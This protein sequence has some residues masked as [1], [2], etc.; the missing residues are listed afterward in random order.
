MID[1]PNCGAENPAGFRFCGSCAAPLP[2]SPAPREQR[3]TVSVLFCD[4]TGSTALGESTDPETLRAQLARYFERMKAIVQA[5][6]GSVEKFIGD[7]VMAIFGVPHVHE[8]DALRAVRAA[9][10][11]RDAL[12]EL[13]LQARIGVNTGE[14]VT[15][16]DERLATGDAVNVAARLEQAATPGEILIGHATFELVRGSVEALPVDPLTVKGKSEPVT[17]HRLVAVLAGTASSPTRHLESPMVGRQTEVRRLADAYEQALRNRSCQMFTILG[18]AGVGKSRLAAEFQQGVDANVVPGRCL[19]YGEGITYWPVI[20]VIRQLPAVQP[21]AAV[22]ETLRSLVDGTATAA[23]ADEIAWAFRKLLEAAARERPLVVVFDDLQWGEETFLDLVEHVA[24]LS[25]DAPI[26][27]LCM[28]RPDLLDRRPTWA[29]GKLNATNVLLEPLSVTETQELIAQLTAPLPGDT[30]QRVVDAAEGNP[31]FVEE[32]VALARGSSA[33]QVFVPPT[34]QALLAARLDQ[35][36]DGERAVLER[37]SIEG[38][39]F[40][41]SALQALAPDQRDGPDQRDV[42]KR[43]TSLVRKELIRP[44]TSRVPGDDAFRFRHLLIRDAAYEALPKSTRA[45]LHERFSR[46]LE[47]HATSVTELDEIL[48]YHLEQACRYR[49]EL[50]QP[51]DEQVAAR[52]RDHLA[53]A[54]RR[55]YARADFGAA[56]A[57][58]ER[59]G[60]QLPAGVIDMALSVDLTNALRENGRSDD[61]LVY[62]TSLAERARSTGDRGAELCSLILAGILRTYREPEGAADYL[63]ELTKDAIPYFEDAHDDL[64]LY[65]AYHARGQ[66]AN[67]R[68]QAV[69][70]VEAYDR[71]AE[72]ARRLGLADQFLVWRSLFRV[73]GTTPASE[74]LAWLEA[75]TEGKP[76]ALANE[77]LRA[78]ALA[79][80]GRTDEAR[81]VIA[82]AVRELEDRG[83]QVTIGEALGFGA[84]VIELLA[85][86]A[87][88]AVAAGEEGC[89]LLEATGEVSFVSAV[90]G[91]L[92]RALV[93]AGRL[94]AADLW[95]R[96]ASELSTSDDLASEMIW[97][98]AQALVLAHRGE[99]TAA[100]KLAQEA[101]SIGAQTQHLNEQ[102]ETYWDLATVLV[103]GD[104]PAEAAEALREAL[105]R[106]E[107]KENLVMA[108]R[109]RRK[110]ESLA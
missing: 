96:R 15:G 20:E 72:Y 55:A 38:R 29:G 76:R 69:A 71:A 50:G 94:D 73:L 11:M 35:L 102:G 43:L 97:R 79:M 9:V 57:L 99:H 37:G 49:R 48:G 18:S 40:H 63:D 75:Q 31:L 67:V 44:D 53:S 105:D 4:V 41:L 74:F 13:G 21:E 1:C 68:A 88:A 58:F 62:T 30:F 66:A 3:K 82:N 107:R 90:A 108:E 106:Y 65:V 8:D 77:Q 32:M 36:D 2:D 22:S 83:A 86:D 12:P 46:W 109:A 28:A 100:K 61:A 24:D 84:L 60:G 45:D 81:S 92:A 70:G 98:Q 103:L 17:A 6:G 14:V 10:E 95:A 52:A 42:M 110:L 85:G 47:E 25:R 51:V 101:V 33:G 16:T 89:R 78:T 64:G 56:V 104:Q 23:S 59:A 26:L 34:I 87:D 54:G 91:M 93:A 5:H 19:P 27:L 39:I 80:L 7:A